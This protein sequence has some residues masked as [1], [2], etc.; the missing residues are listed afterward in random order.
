M[1]ADGGT[2]RK[3]KEVKVTATR[4]ADDRWRIRSFSVDR[5]KEQ[6]TRVNG[7]ATGNLKVVRGGKQIN[8]INV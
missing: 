1:T 3:K 8:G 6:Q 2:A 4:C 7:V 5:H